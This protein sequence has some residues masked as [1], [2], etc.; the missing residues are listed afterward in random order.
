MPRGAVQVKR[1]AVV[2]EEP[3]VKPLGVRARDIW[4]KNKFAC[5]SLAIV[6]ISW[7]LVEWFNRNRAI[8]SWARSQGLSYSG[9]YDY[10][11]AKKHIYFDILSRG[12]KSYAYNVMKGTST[13]E[14]QT[15]KE[16]ETT[17]IKA[18][19]F[20]YTEVKKYMQSK[21][22]HRIERTQEFSAV[23]FDAPDFKFQSTVVTPRALI[24]D[25]EETAVP[26]QADKDT[27]ELIQ[28]AK[29]AKA[30]KTGKDEDSTNSSNGTAVAEGNSSNSTEAETPKT[31][32][33]EALKAETHPLSTKF[34]ETFRVMAQDHVQSAAMMGPALK[35][36]LLDNDKFFVDFQDEQFMLYKEHTMEPDEYS[37]AMKL[38]GAILAN[39]PSVL[40]V[41]EVATTGKKKKA[42][43]DDDVSVF[44]SRSEL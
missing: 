32:K 2:E 42:E 26:T 38:G 30:K 24:V 3:P 9:S 5:V 17:N 11:L 14:N 33:E 44:I 28:K 1:K 21:K 27:E 29:A 12:T 7:V 23:M 16:Q 37:A 13:F 35:Q 19:D 31:P 34:N 43:V 15:T 41:K 4:R 25:A 18:F 8:G 40:P 22:I 6:I 36:L 39:L 10:K 20:C